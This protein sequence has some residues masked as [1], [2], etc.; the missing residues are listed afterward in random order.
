MRNTDLKG[1]FGN[2]SD[3]NISVSALSGVQ[4]CPSV[5]LKLKRDKTIRWLQAD[6][7]LTRDIH[8]AGRCCKVQTVRYRPTLLSDDAEKIE[9]IFYLFICFSHLNT[10][11]K[12][13]R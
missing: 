13:Y 8:P 9:N 4:D 10:A 11:I 7:S 6:S 5:T 1:W 3:S 2:H 12:I